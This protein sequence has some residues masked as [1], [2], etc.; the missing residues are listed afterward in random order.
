MAFFD[1]WLVGDERITWVVYLVYFTALIGAWKIFWWVLAPFLSCARHKCICS[2]DIRRKY[3]RRDNRAYAV[4]TGGSD[5]IGLELCNQ[6]AENGFNICMISRNKA[7]V[8][9]KLE[10]I[11][12]KYPSVATHA[13]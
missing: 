3:G 13:V 12:Q 9:K 10:E 6:F 8:E 5:G 7:K 1:K 2:Q 11:K 4:V